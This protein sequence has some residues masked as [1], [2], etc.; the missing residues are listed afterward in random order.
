MAGGVHLGPNAG[1]FQRAL[2]QLGPMKETLGRLF[3]QATATFSYEAE[4]IPRVFST[5]PEV[6]RLKELRE[7]YFAEGIFPESEAITHIK[8]R[9]SETGF[10]NKEASFREMS[11]LREDG[12]HTPISPE[13]FKAIISNPAD[14]I[15]AIVSHSKDREDPFEE[16]VDYIASIGEKEDSA[17]I[18]EIVARIEEPAI[19]LEKEVAA[20]EEEANQLEEI[21]KDGLATMKKEEAAVKKKAAAKIRDEANKVRAEEI[22][23]R[24]GKEEDVDHERIVGETEQRRELVQ[25]MKEA[26]GERDLLSNAVS[27]VTEKEEIGELVD[28]TADYLSDKLASTA[29]LSGNKHF[30]FMGKTGTQSLGATGVLNIPFLD[31]V[32][33]PEVKPFLTEK[34][35]KVIS[36][37][38]R[39]ALIKK[40]GPMIMDLIGP[41][42]IRELR[43]ELEN[44]AADPLTLF[45][46]YTG[47]IFQMLEGVFNKLVPEEGTAEILRS[48]KEDIREAFCG[49]RR[50]VPES[51][52]TEIEKLLDRVSDQGLKESIEKTAEETFMN[53][54]ELCK[55][56]MYSIFKL[57]GQYI[58]SSVIAAA[59]SEG[60]VP[61]IETPFWVDFAKNDDETYTVKLFANGLGAEAFDEVTVDE[62]T[63]LRFPLIFESVPAEKLSK[64]FFHLLLDYEYRPKYEDGVQSYSIEHVVHGVTQYLGEPKVADTVNEVIPHSIVEDGS[65]LSLVQL[66]LFSN[67]KRDIKTFYSE[68][69]FD[70]T[71]HAFLDYWHQCGTFEKL[72]KDQKLRLQ[73]RFVISRLSKEAILLNT[74]KVIS[75]QKLQ[76]I[77]A[78]FLEIEKEMG[79]V[80]KHMVKDRRGGIVVPPQIQD[81]LKALLMAS[82]ADPAYL[83]AVKE[84][85]LA[86]AG[87]DCEEI[88]DAALHELLPE[89]VSSKTIKEAEVLD[90]HEVFKIKHVKEK[91]DYLTMNRLSIFQGV[92]FYAKMMFILYT[93]Y[94]VTVSAK[95]VEKSI[96]RWCPK[97]IKAK[98]PFGSF[99]V[100]MILTLFGPHV[101][102]K[103]LPKDVYESIAAIYHLASQV[104]WYLLKRLLMNGFKYGIKMSL[105]K[106]FPDEKVRIREFAKKMQQ[107]ILRKGDLGYEVTPSEG[108]SDT[109]DLNLKKG[110]FSEA[111]HAKKGTPVFKD[112]VPRPEAVI[113]YD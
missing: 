32:I 46:K 113:P 98:L 110:A 53:V 52:K 39:E 63:G 5:S 17:R 42:A 82:G 29:H 72:R 19:L 60:V 76:R 33:P 7:K 18:D 59:T 77:C 103:I 71:F 112:S 64:E 96:E 4:R 92:K 44:P 70:L 6:R 105:E 109:V 10:L 56:K 91:I 66:Y 86:A 13:A 30:L 50:D 2:I 74:D 25:A 94:R 24:A 48:V 34:D 88:F 95:L 101:F 58:P 36:Q 90:W 68:Q 1:V 16:M 40:M 38:A 81:K 87:D 89:L 8:D 55:E 9:L 35:P 106:H 111:L 97:N 62:E 65:P 45:E 43:D 107:E 22:L 75:C 15:K 80:E 78:T 104:T 69:S 79:K 12:D 27:E 47:R 41:G 51:E 28:K 100:G 14:R 84:V 31:Q 93:M 108:N 54:Q 73:V 37:M 102:A 61:N 83:E 67:Q 26:K 49:V 57:V 3:H 85:F 20:L 11:H 99:Q 23:C 21:G